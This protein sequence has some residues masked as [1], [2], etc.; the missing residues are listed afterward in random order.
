MLHRDVGWGR[1][2]E[3][4]RKRKRERAVPGLEPVGLVAGWRMGDEAG[5]AWWWHIGKRC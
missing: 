4:Q 1:R 5:P 2:G 3:R